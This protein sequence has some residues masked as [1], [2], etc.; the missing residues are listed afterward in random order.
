MDLR[1]FDK[2]MHYSV[3]FFVPFIHLFVNWTVRFNSIFKRE[4]FLD[5]WSDVSVN[6]RYNSPVIRKYA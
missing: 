4:L 5:L 1:P 3:W 2:Y 6:L